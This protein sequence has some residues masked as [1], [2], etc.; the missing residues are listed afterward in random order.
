M[1]DLSRCP[2]KPYDHQ[3]VGV[4]A[5]VKMDDPATGRIFPGCFALF[6]EMGAGKTL[7]TIAAAQ[8]LFERNELDKVI[9]VAPASVRPVWFDPELGELKKHLWPD[10]PARISEYHGRIRQWT[11]GPKAERV[12]RWAIT[13]Y[14]FIRDKARLK[15][16][17]RFADS[18]TLLV[19]DESSAVKGHRS[20]QTRA[21]EKLRKVCGRV[22]LLNGTPIANNPLDLYA[23]G[24]LMDPR[25]LDSETF[26]HFRAKYAIVVG[27]YGF[28][29]ITGWQNL[30]E[31]QKKMAPYVLRRLKEDCLDLPSKLPAV[32]LTVTMDDEE[33]APYKQM[34]DEMVAWL[35]S[36]K[37]G[38]A[39]QA[40]IKAMRLAQITSGFLGGVQELEEDELLDDELTEP[41]VNIFDDR[42]SFIPR[43][44]EAGRPPW[45]KAQAGRVQR[46]VQRSLPLVE[47]DNLGPR[48]DPSK[49]IDGIMDVGRSKLNF[50]IEW[51]GARL[52][53]DKNFKLLAW[54][55]FRPELARLV[56][57]VKRVYPHV[58]IEEIRGGQK[59]GERQRALRLLDPRTAPKGPAI[60]AGTPASGSMGLNL[61]AAHTVI[62]LSNDYRPLTRQQSEDRV[63][64]P[65][66]VNH[67]SYFDVV[68][69]GPRGQRTVDHLI[70]KSL[71]EKWDVATL[72]T[73]AWVSALTDEEPV[74]SVVFEPTEEDD[75]E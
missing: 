45:V 5:L 36:D 50:F 65:G 30:D 33:W 64:R 13:N 42:P 17:M 43:G 27:G 46:P 1:L 69:V 62:Y 51:L 53:E 59:K 71:R 12:L 25:I 24:R 19:L 6:D 8:V 26:T 70:A 35:S 34:R 4:E 2:V 32:S 73:S 47:V 56:A 67:V 58:P 54:C 21:C 72:T 39:S 20:K 57:E 74:T 3:I 14:D 60:V 75:D 16:L 15:F 29:K 68:A 38:V 44:A 22:V 28:P 11:S 63:H 9:V 7:Q 41:S 40:A 31:L 52:S 10:L 23:Q 61:T 55:R 18:R 48:P 49:V 37:V 66:Q